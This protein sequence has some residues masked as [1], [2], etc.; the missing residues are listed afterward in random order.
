MP[1]VRVK[2]FNAKQ[3]EILYKYLKTQN[4]ETSCPK[5]LWI[6]K[7]SLCFFISLAL[8]SDMEKKN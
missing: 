4:N 5:N 1:G 6:L 7:N 8:I 3:I 2:N